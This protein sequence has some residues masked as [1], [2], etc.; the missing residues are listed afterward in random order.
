[1]GNTATRSHT[2]KGTAKA[3]PWEAA[4]SASLTPGP[5]YSVGD[6]PAAHRKKGGWHSALGTARAQGQHHGWVTDHNSNSTRGSGPGLRVGPDQGW[7]HQ[8]RDLPGTPRLLPSRQRPAKE[9][10]CPGAVGIT[11]SHHTSVAEGRSGP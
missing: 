2:S 7:P 11:P 3:Q 5:L 1:M 6:R 4:G 9:G 8:P 10:R